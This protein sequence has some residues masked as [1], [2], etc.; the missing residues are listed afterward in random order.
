MRRGEIWLAK[1]DCFRGFSD[2]TAVVIVGSEALNLLP[3]RLVVPLVEWKAAHERAA[4]MAPVAFAAAG[5][6]GSSQ[7][8]AVNRVV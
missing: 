3:L 6:S 5:E 2:P 1:E 8:E 4:W 7:A